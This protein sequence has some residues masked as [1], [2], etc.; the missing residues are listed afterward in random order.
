VGVG[1]KKSNGQD[2]YRMV[3]PQSQSFCSLQGGFYLQPVILEFSFQQFIPLYRSKPASVFVRQ[4]KGEKK[5]VRHPDGSFREYPILTFYFCV[6]RDLA[7]KGTFRQ[8]HHAVGAAVAL[9][10]KSDKPLNELSREELVS[11]NEKFGRDASSVFDLQRA[12]TRRNLIGAPGT[13]QVAKQLAKWRKV[14]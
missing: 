14:L 13:K 3:M 5:K 2:V 12:M 4:K 10:E 7:H 9:A 6:N 8:A 1:N 11:I